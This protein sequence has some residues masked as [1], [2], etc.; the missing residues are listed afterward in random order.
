MNTSLPRPRRIHPRKASRNPG[1][2]GGCENDLLIHHLTRG[3]SA[4]A[5]LHSSL[6]VETSEGLFLR[7]AASICMRAFAI[8]LLD[9]VFHA[10]ILIPY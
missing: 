1:S 4:V 3:P 2:S 10:T 6:R 8:G 5:P 9:A 7:A